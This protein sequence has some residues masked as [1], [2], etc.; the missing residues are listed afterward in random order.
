MSRDAP[1]E[2]RIRGLVKESTFKKAD[3]QT[4]PS[5]AIFRAATASACMMS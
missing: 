4:K 3:L 5:C 2:I 1:Y